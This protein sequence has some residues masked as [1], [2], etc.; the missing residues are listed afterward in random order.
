VINPTKRFVL[1]KYEVAMI[2]SVGHAAAAKLK[3]YF[4]FLSKNTL[5][6]ENV[7]LNGIIIA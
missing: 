4:N 6:F 7:V 3:R 2:D 5:E 1:N